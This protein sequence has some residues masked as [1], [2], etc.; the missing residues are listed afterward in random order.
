M[1]RSEMKTGKA[2]R[3][4]SSGFTLVELMI[5]IAIIGILAA[6]AIPNYFSY[7]K[8]AKIILISHLGR[9]KGKIN[10]KYTLRVAVEPLK[11]LLKVPV[12]LLL[13]RRNAR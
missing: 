9:P 8:K 3:L 5:V 12:S 1:K 10:P 11:S 6:I 4:S 13:Y 7:R 2:S